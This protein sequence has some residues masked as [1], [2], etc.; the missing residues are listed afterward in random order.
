MQK[1]GS[2]IVTYAVFIFALVIILINLVSLVFPSLIV[3]LLDDSGFGG[4]P[5]EL[6]TWAIHVIVTNIAFLI[7]GI[8]YF[9]K[10]LPGFIQNSINFI[11][12]YEVSRN[13]ATIVVVGIVFGYIGFAMAEPDIEES[14]I[15]G[16]YERVK[17]VVEKWPFV[18]DVNT[19]LYNLHVKNFL[20]KS[21]QFLF[22]NFRVIPFIESISLL[23][24]TYFFTAEFTKKRLAGI[25]S[26]IILLQSYTFRT[27]DTIASYENSWILF[28]LL[29]LFLITKKWQLSPI[30]YVASVFS[31]PL[32]VPYLPLTL[33]FTYRSEIPRRKKIYILISYVIIV[34]LGIIGLLILGID[35]GGNIAERGLNFDHIDFLRAFTAW[36][37]QLRF[38]GLFLLFI[39]P[40]IVALFFTSRSGFPQADSVLFL[41]AGI[42]VVMPLLVGLTSF[43]IHPYR[44]VSLIVFFA[45]GVGTL[46][47]KS[48]KSA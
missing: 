36:S 24:L 46:L 30:S 32:T 11:K 35:F 40:L 19:G 38:D 34:I 28:Y 6:G 20:L 12:N 1:L 15:F 3:T 22:N 42:I 8:L 17:L 16:D 29:S 44:Y 48:I 5:F 23:I 31:K 39:L 43:N 21:S 25:V 13:V 2:G 33:F 14:T 18:N 37:F 45:I 27:F 10:K 47:S 7:F 9:S 26:M 4:N 41:I